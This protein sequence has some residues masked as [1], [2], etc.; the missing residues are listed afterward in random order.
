MSL[1][2][3]PFE[4]KVQASIKVLIYGQPGL[5]KSTLALSAPAPLLLDFDNGVHRI[6][7][8]HQTDTVQIE[9]WD[10]VLAVLKEDLSNY[11]TLVIDTASKMLDYMGM[12]LIAKNPKLGKANGALSLQGYGERKAEFNNF[13]KQVSLSGK[14]LVFVAHDKEEKEGDNKIVRPDIG[15]TSGGDLIK[16]LDLVGYMEAIGKKRTISFDPCER[17]YGKNTCNLDSVIELTHLEQGKANNMLTS[18][19]NDYHKSLETRKQIGVE[20]N[21][22]ME[23]V[24]EKIES[25][26]D[27]DTANEVMAWAKGYENFIWDAK[28]LASMGISKKAKELELVF[29]KKTNLYTNP[30]VKEDAAA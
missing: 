16:E 13:L 12:Y 2:K 20:Y 14:H 24:N 8:L 4:L 21:K 9:K 23:V 22:L 17:F 26:K 29:E 3:K 7:T 10:D 27:A 18:I 25:I 5:G 6:S 11:K 1:I 15:G 30:K 28:L 19:F